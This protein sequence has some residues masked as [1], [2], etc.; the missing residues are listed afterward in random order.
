MDDK[1]TKKALI[2]SSP[3]DIITYNATNIHRLLLRRGL[4]FSGVQL[5]KQYKYIVES[6]C[7]SSLCEPGDWAVVFPDGRLYRVTSNLFNKMF[8][9]NMGLSG[10]GRPCIFRDCTGIYGKIHGE[11][12]CSKCGDLYPN[13]KMRKN[14]YI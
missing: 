11:I 4:I 7:G 3:M 5:N 14:K 12:R 10:I 13:E 9:T 8:D 1:S 6:P 2:I